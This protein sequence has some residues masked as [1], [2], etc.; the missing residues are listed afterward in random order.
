M[1][2]YGTTAGLEVG[3]ASVNAALKAS[4]MLHVRGADGHVRS[5]LSCS[6]SDLWGAL[7]GAAETDEA[8]QTAKLLKRDLRYLTFV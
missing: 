6:R 4:F 1:G 3:G 2:N 8:E 7:L 5:R